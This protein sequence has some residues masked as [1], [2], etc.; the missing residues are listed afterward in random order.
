MRTIYF[1]HRP[2]FQ[3]HATTG[4][5]MPYYSVGPDLSLLDQ[6]FN[7]CLCPNNFWTSRL[8]KQTARAQIPNSGRVILS[9]TTPVHP[10][11]GRL[12]SRVKSPCRGNRLLPHIPPPEGFP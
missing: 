6:K 3:A 9:P 7:L 12:D 8:D 1:L 5:Y 10:N 4:I 2:E 11:V